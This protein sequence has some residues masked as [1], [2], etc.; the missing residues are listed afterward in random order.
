[1]A[2]I[3]RYQN[4]SGKIL[5]TVRYRTPSHRQTRKR[6]FKT[7]RDAE[8]FAASIEVSKAKGEYISTSAGRMTIGDLG[9]DWLARQHGHMKPSGYSQ[10]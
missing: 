7:K 6:G 8:L 5:Y 4:A 3:E 10:L 9:A 2:T 1:M